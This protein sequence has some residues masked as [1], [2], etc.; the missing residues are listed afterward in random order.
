MIG[1]RTRQPSVDEE[2]APPAAGSFLPL[3]ARLDEIGII[4]HSRGR[5]PVPDSGHCT[6]DAG[7]A[8]AL[9]ARLH[10]RAGTLELADA[11]LT[12]LER[13]ALPTGRFVLRLD[14]DGRPTEDAPTDDAD[15]R[16]V[17]GLASATVSNLP[18]A[19]R[20]RAATLLADVH[21]SQSHHPRAAAQL[22]VAGGALMVDE[23]CSAWGE[24]L[25]VANRCAVPQPLTP[26]VGWAWPE[27]RLTYANGLVVEALLDLAALIDVR[28][29]MRDAL[30]LLRWLV[31]H[32]TGPGGHFSFTPVAGRGPDDPPGYDQQP[33]EAWSLAGACARAAMLTGSPVW[34]GICERLT[35]W[36]DGANDQHVRMWDPTTRASFDGLTSDG[37]NLNQGTESTLAL[38]GT[39]HALEIAAQ[40]LPSAAMRSMR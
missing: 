12:Q 19:L 28:D 21:R 5:V 13:C 33:I 6:D 1:G 36:F 32:E 20:S 37:V 29:R 35:N 17:W 11:C 7:R 26:Q 34:V 4:E 16:A 14:A 18:P 38:I 30:A 25:V 23:T 15:A 22:V 40:S 24:R 8:L 10:P 39:V 31:D 27:P 2:G 3:L 9:A